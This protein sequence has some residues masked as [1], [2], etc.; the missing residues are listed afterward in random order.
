MEQP[1]LDE[2]APDERLRETELVRQRI[3]HRLQV[4]AVEPPGIDHRI[5]RLSPVGPERDG[6]ARL[7]CQTQQVAMQW[8]GRR[9]EGAHELV[10]PPFPPIHRPIGAAAVAQVLG[11]RRDDAE[12]P[13]HHRP[14]AQV[15]TQLPLA[16]NRRRHVEHRMAQL[17]ARGAAQQIGPLVK[18]LPVETDHHLVGFVR[19]VLAHPHDLPPVLIMHGSTDVPDHVED[20]TVEA[21]EGG[22]LNL[23]VADGA[24]D[25]AVGDTFTI[26]VSG[27]G[28][29]VALDPAAVDGTAEAVGIA[30]F[31]VTAPDGTDAAVTAILRDAILA[32]RAIVWPAGITEARKNAAIADLVARGILVRKAA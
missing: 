29:V 23:T 12:R 9:Q 1:V 6:Q 10:R 15:Q 32:D 2:P 27:D 17:M 22:H 24:A 14:L 8:I 13:A 19:V 16:L 3:G 26:E 30:A 4:G 31:D 20:D 5:A 21:Y 28:T 25:F 18:N 7:S 11:P